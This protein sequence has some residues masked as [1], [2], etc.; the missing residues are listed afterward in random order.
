MLVIP[1]KIQAKIEHEDH[2]SITER[3]VRECFMAWDGR[4]CADTREDHTTQSGLQTRWFVGESH[5]GRCLKI[6]YVEDGENV[7]LKSAYLATTEV[8]RIFAKYAQN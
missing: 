2:G 4:Y 1:Q 6:M 3:E 5:V 7:Y 8:Q